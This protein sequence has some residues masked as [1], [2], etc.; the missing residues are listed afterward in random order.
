MVLAGVFCAGCA[1]YATPGGPAPLSA[2]NPGEA[3]AAPAFPPVVNHPVQVTLVR[4]QA[5][6]Y[7]A[8][9]A[10]RIGN[11]GFSVVVPAERAARPLKAVAQWPW[12]EKA[13]ALKPAL[14]PER[15]NTLDD[16]RLA[17]AKNLA[18]LL[19]VYT[20]DTQFEID[21][22]AL[23][24]LADLSTGKAPDG[25]AAIRS[26]AVAVLIDVRSGYRYG[27]VEASARTDDLSGAWLTAGA[28]DRKRM[29]T[30]Q[31]AVD[32]LLQAAGAMWRQAVP[33]TAPVA[34]SRSDA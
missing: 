11:G 26:G 29:D 12:V 16:L 24:P 17:A 18:D 27:Q 5:A 8:L 2:L 32:A 3:S 19:V 30:E 31:Q 33:P 10:E 20:V 15:L 22:R 28:L 7:A 34:A 1:S 9:S 23:A 25:S 21:G 4:V 13:E 6:D 14:L